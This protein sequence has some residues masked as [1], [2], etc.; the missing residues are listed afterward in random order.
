MEGTMR[1]MRANRGKY[2]VT[3]KHDQESRQVLTLAS[4]ST[5]TKHK[6]TGLSPG[7]SMVLRRRGWKAWESGNVNRE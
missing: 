3:P 1:L 2:S 4:T 6:H 7:P 5:T